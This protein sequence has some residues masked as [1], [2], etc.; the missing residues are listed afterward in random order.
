MKTPASHRRQHAKHQHDADR[1]QKRRRVEAHRGPLR[2][3]RWMPRRQDLAGRIAP[4]M[5]LAYAGHR[6]AAEDQLRALKRPFPVAEEVDAPRAQVRQLGGETSR[7]LWR[8]V[9]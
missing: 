2:A 9:R 1:R 7:V 8:G 4:S 6:H 3:G 5:V